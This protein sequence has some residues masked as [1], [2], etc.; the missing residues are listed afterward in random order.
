[1]TSYKGSYKGEGQIMRSP[2]MQELVRQVALGAMAYAVSIAPVRTTQLKRKPPPGEYK[3]SF[4]VQVSAH[5]GPPG[6]PRAEAVLVNTSD[7]A[8]NV[9]WQDNYLVLTRTLGYLELG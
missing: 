6:K 2:E 9:E 4:E 7:H 5:G 1:M 8:V 3:D